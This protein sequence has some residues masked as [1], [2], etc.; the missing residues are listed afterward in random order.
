V[1]QETP[2]KR[3]IVW[4]SDGRALYFTEISR[5]TEITFFGESGVKDRLKQVI[6]TGKYFLRRKERNL[7]YRFG[8]NGKLFEISDPNGNSITLAYAG[9]LLTQV[10]DNFGKSLSIQYNAENRIYSI[11]EPKN[12]TVLY[13]YTNGDLTQVTYPDQNF[14]RYAYLNHHLTDKYDTNINLVGHWEYDTWDRVINYYSHLKE[15]IPQERIDLTYELGRSLLTRS[16]GITTYATEI[17]D[18]IV[19]VKEIEGCSTC[20][21]VHK[22]FSYTNR[23]NLAQ[24]TSINGTTEYTTLYTYDDPPNPWEQVGEVVEMR[25]A[26]GWPEERTTLYSYTH[27]TDDPFLLTQSTETK[28]SVVDSLWA[29]IGTGTKITLM[30]PFKWG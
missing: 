6:S 7:T 2:P 27:R 1:V 9:G 23:L 14:M 22:R 21:G 13:E 19:V 8:S 11:T 29:T 30:V 3:V 18:G 15:G 24:V 28:K 5:T 26:L 10:S 17:I 4:D 12:Q 20:G 25:E 16:T